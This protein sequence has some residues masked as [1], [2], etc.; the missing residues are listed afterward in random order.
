M[1]TLDSTFKTEKNAQ[2]NQPIFLY[3]IEDYDGASNDLNYAEY[4]TDIVY[5]GIT[6]SKFPI[7]HEF[8]SENTKGE[9]DQVKVTVANVSRAIEA[10][11]TAYDLRGKKV[12]I[13]VVWANQ[14]ADADAYIEEIY[15]IDSYTA[16][17]EKV[18]F[19]LS[20]KFDILDVAVPVRTY[21]RNY[22]AW[23]FK[24]SEC[25]YSGEETSCNKTLTRCRVLAN[26]VRF[27]GFPSIPSDRVYAG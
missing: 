27:G 23:K 4:D 11:L 20:S 1:K 18:E 15:Y 13:K 16:D 19:T 17:E 9:I 8:I 22:C 12:S 2:S 14:L 26:E 6:Y 10:Y 5:G 7:T 21:L 3:T 24:S 25:G